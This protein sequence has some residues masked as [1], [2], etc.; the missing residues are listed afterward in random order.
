M[1]SIQ[2]GFGGPNSLKKGDF[3]V[4]GNAELSAEFVIVDGGNYFTNVSP[5]K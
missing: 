3:N 1:P 4:G 5:A 2:G